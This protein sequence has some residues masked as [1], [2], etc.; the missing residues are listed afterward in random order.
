MQAA[1]ARKDAREELALA[2]SVGMT[3]AE[4]REVIRHVDAP[5]WAV[6]SVEAADSMEAADMAAVAAV[7]P[8]LI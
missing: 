5:A 1:L 6:D 7:S 4:R 8:L 2:H 3:A